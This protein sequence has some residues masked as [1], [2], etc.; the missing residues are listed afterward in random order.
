MFSVVSDF[1]RVV[2]TPPHS[3]NTHT[4][5]HLSTGLYLCISTLTAH[6]RLILC[7]FMHSL[8]STQTWTEIFKSHQSYF[9]IGYIENCLM[10][11]TF[12]HMCQCKQKKK[13]NN[14][15]TMKRYYVL[16][17]NNELLFLFH[18]ALHQSF[19]EI[20]KSTATEEYS[21]LNCSSSLFISW[22][23]STNCFV[24]SLCLL[25]LIF[26]YIVSGTSLA[27]RFYLCFVF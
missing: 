11:S 27:R 6:M 22:N 10:I 1:N 8:R 3:S 15:V 4:N 23:N 14:N 24:Y 12:W 16:I 13:K 21:Q 25:L 7:L 17:H 20:E 9:I 19:C 26:N 2:L 18:F 5:I